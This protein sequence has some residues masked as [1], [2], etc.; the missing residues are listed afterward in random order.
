MHIKLDENLGE[1]GRELFA[2]AG[3][4]VRTVKDQGLE[5]RWTHR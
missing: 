4:D 3:H 1:R 5:G 2:I